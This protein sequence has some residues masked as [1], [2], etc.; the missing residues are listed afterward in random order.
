MFDYHVPST[1]PQ[2]FLP[3]QGATIA[4][5]TDSQSEITMTPSPSSEEVSFI[6]EEANRYLDKTVSNSDVRSAW[7]GIRPLAKVKRIVSD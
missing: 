6:I 3:W 1:S 2:F 4:G 7:S 5:T